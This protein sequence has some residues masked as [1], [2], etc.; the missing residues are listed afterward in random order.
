[1]IPLTIDGIPVEVDDGATV[2]DAAKKAGV[3][4]PTLCHDDRLKP[5]GACRMCLVEVNAGPK[6]MAACTTPAAKD[7]AV[8]TRND[9]ILKIRQTLLELLCV[10]H[11]LD[12]PVCDAAGECRLQDL[13]FG[14]EQQKNRFDLPRRDAPSDTRAPLVER[15][16][17]RCIS[18]YRCVRICHEAQGVGAIGLSKR[19]YDTKIGPPLG[20]VLDC[21]F[22]GQC[23]ATCPVGALT[24][25]VFKFRARTWFLSR[26]PSTCPHCGTGCRIGVEH[27]KGKVYRITAKV[28]EGI[29]NGNLCPKGR[30]G[31]EFVNSEDRLA[32][33]LLRG[34]GKPSEVPWKDA[35]DG[36]AKGL[37]KVLDA[38]GPNA[39]GLIGSPRLT[40][41]E[42]YLL[43]KLARAGIGTNN[44]DTLACFGHAHHLEGARKAFGALPVFPTYEDI[45]KAKTLFVIDSAVTETNP[46]IGNL[47]IRAM[48]ESGA[49]VVLLSPRGSKLS[50]HAT[51]W[52][53]HRPGAAGALLLAIA[54]VMAKGAAKAVKGLPGFDAFSKAL[55]DYSPKAVAK[56]CGVNAATVKALAERLTKEG[57]T[58]FLLGLPSYENVKGAATW[59][60]AYNLSLLAQ[61]S[62]EGRLGVMA[63]TEA[64]NVQGALDMG[65]APGS[66]PGGIPFE[67]KAYRAA[68]GKAWGKEIPTHPGLDAWGMIEAA[69]AGTLKGLIVAGENPFFNFPDASRVEKALKKL[70]YLLV[71]DPFQ[72]ETSAVAEAILPAS[73]FAEK[74][75]TFTNTELR[76][77][78]VNAAV[79]P[80]GNA[81]PD[82]YILAEL[83]KRLGMPG[84]YEDEGAIAAEIA[85]VQ[86]AFR[87]I[88]DPARTGGEGVLWNADP[89]GKSAP[90]FLDGPWPKIPDKPAKGELTLLTGTLL[91][92]SGTV[93]RHCP[94]L[95]QVVDGARLRVHPEDAK[96]LGLEEGDTAKVKASEGDAVEATVQLDETLVQGTV[97]LPVHF[98]A[99]RTH[100]LVSPPDADGERSP[101]RITV[102]KIRAKVEAGA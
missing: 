83:G 68:L 29:N 8:V 99:A 22:C 38:S 1:M 88:E 42:N 40:N 81:R 63:P 86:P 84:E 30:F 74:T 18:C 34:N 79:P 45:P 12:C 87:G 39:I 37:K 26:T 35:L 46:V 2:L 98:E 66:L 48:R 25:K 17:N 77:Q 44:V 75:G 73:T 95:H 97:F 6:L 91:N 55:K 102:E 51:E 67:D 53:Q 76:I 33:P 72:T 61:A 9:R 16:L 31:Y 28:G 56:K 92:H 15:N 24:S 59:T 19:G 80:V 3:E 36:A 96:S 52:V 21:E 65:A 78:R 5:Y 93:T 47:L 62:G 43:Q 89:G 41:E 7:M 54:N 85:T 90:S 94:G 4:I 13:V 50:R 64:A 11:P 14:Q 27:M 101:V 58:L 23:I 69:E 82:W 57:P 71:I 49:Q 32:A 100:L 20:K 60:A 70:D 10:H